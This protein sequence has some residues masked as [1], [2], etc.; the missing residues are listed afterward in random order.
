[1]I[2]A[3]GPAQ[4][5]VAGLLFLSAPSCGGSKD[6]PNLTEVQRARSGMLEVVLLS[7]TGGLR[8]GKDDFVIEFRSAPG[9]A[10]VDVGTVKGSATMSMAGTPMLGSIDIKKTDV[11]GRYEATSDLSMAGTWRTTIE[12]TGPAGQGSVTFSGS[13]Q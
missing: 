11:P 7:P 6:G 12:W 3:G 5:I 8:H 9:G 2:G 13:V 4:W 1:M 10:L